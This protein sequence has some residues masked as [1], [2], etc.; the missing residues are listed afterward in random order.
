MRRYLLDNL[1]EFISEHTGQD[2]VEYGMIVAVIAIVVLLGV[3]AFGSLI[4]P[5]FQHLATK[6][7]T[8]GT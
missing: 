8:V 3:T 7:T 2:V 5:W 4:E 6:I 1:L